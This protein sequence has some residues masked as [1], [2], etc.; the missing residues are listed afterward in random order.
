[1]ITRVGATLLS[2]LIGLPAAASLEAATWDSSTFENLCTSG[3]LRACASVRVETQWDDA[4]EVTRVRM[5]VRNL[6]GENPIDDTGGYLIQTIGITAPE[7]GTVNEESPF[8]TTDGEVG[9][10]AGSHGD[11]RDLWSVSHDGDGDGGRRIGGSVEFSAMVDRGSKGGIEGC[12]A[13]DSHPDSRFNTC[14]EDGY[15]GWVAF[16]FTTSERWSAEEV[17]V[18]WGGI[19]AANDPDWSDQCRSDDP[20]CGTSVVPEPMTI[21]LLGTGLAGVG[22]ATRRRRRLDGLDDEPEA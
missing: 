16:N 4:A 10:S 22:A 17:E 14:S 9:I 12:D 20:T 11:P 19:S 8:V 15:T 5:Y 6:Q 13:S 1:M 7:I 18:A 3:T 21:V 2:L